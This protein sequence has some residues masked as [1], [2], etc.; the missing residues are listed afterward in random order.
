[1]AHFESDMCTKL[2]PKLKP[3]IIGG[4]NKSIRHAQSGFGFSLMAIVV[5]LA[6]GLTISIFLRQV[7]TQSA[8]YVQMYS[9]S[10]ARWSA[11]SGIEW[12]IYK[13]ELG[14][15]DVL[16][17][18]DFFNSSIDIDTSAADENGTPLTT[19]YYRILSTANFGDAESRFRIIAA[20]SMQEAW[21]DVSIIEQKGD[22]KSGFTLNDT[23]YFGDDVDI[24][25]GAFVGVG[26]GEPTHFYHP[27]GATV[28]PS[29]GTNWT[30][31]VHPLGN[32]YL[33]DFDN[34]YYD[35]HI[36]IADAITSTTDNKIYTKKGTGTETW[37][38]EELD[39]SGYTDNT[40][41]VAGKVVL[42]SVHLTGGSIDSPGILVANNTITLQR[43][44]T[45]K[46]KNAVDGPITTAD[47]NI[48]LISKTDIILD[49]STYFGEDH[50]ATLPAEDRPVTTNELYAKDDLQIK[51]GTTAWGQLYCRDDIKLEGS[52][53][54]ICY[55][56][57]KFTFEKA[58]SYLEGAV[59][60]FELNKDDLKLGQMVLNHVFHDEYFK[61]INYGVEDNSL[62]EN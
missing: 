15:D 8:E 2:L 55:A 62:L 24:D 50:S 30:S 32:L 29:S 22:I 3:V 12:G 44:V 28:D 14:E 51:A 34:S 39:L 40:L 10:Q 49:D 6:M 54:G 4:E 35:D 45:G 59:F 23:L 61:V 37:S 27:I 47:D 11:M 42:E 48:I 58:S 60:A 17:S 41:Y 36:A 38:D 26:G 18:F 46:D 43:S 33:P 56:P 16:G 13:A 7:S 31:G 9:A 25:G 57:S 20:F 53:Y 1:M 5:A 52:V 19:N 21:A